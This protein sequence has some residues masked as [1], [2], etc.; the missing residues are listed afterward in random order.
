MLD[1]LAIEVWSKGDVSRGHLFAVLKRMKDRGC[2]DPCRFDEEFRRYERELSRRAPAETSQWTFY[3]PLNIT[4]DQAIPRPAAIRVLGKRFV[5]GTW[6]TAFKRAGERTLLW[7]AGR[8]T[9]KP[10][11]PL[12]PTCLM[13]TTKSVDFYAAW[14]DI[15]P[16]FDA[17]RGLIELTLG[18]GSMGWSAPQRPRHRVSCP[19]WAIGHSPGKEPQWLTFYV[20]EEDKAANPFNITQHVW[21]GL[22]HN[23]SISARPA[24]ANSAQALL[25]DGLRLYSQAMDARLNHECFLGL[26]QLAE[27]VTMANRHQGK[28]N[29]VCS[30]LAWFARRWRKT[31]ASALQ[32]CLGWLYEKR[33]KVVH[34][35]LHDH[36][37]HNDVNVLKVCCETALKW[38]S[39]RVRHVA[40]ANELEHFYRLSDASDN[41]LEELKRAMAHVKKERGG[42]RSKR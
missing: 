42:G 11:P 38:L 3:F 27:A 12:T 35:G 16:A 30:R 29:V 18:L 7:T 6:E 32:D 2:L 28:K 20:H 33:N 31:D 14:G 23:S 10:K 39:G 41:N 24:P 34:R 40:T 5:F 22:K 37:D 21:D 15:E 4:I 36:V 26:W 25:A 9:G 13:V 8:I 1:V 19:L 17:F